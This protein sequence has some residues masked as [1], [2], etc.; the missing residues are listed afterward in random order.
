MRWG[1]L[2]HPAAAPSLR[3]PGLKPPPSISPVSESHW[4]PS[5]CRAQG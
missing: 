1:F 2:F 3:V 4:L 5:P